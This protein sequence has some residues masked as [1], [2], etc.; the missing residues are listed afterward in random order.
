MAQ[1]SAHVL[2]MVGNGRGE[3][4]GD[5]GAGRTQDNHHGGSLRAPVTGSH[6]FGIGTTRNVLKL[7]VSLR[8]F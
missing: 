5:S 7:I 4:K 8:A 6:S 2:L 3:H 1:Q